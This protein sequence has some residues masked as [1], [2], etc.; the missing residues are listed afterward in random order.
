MRPTR[1]PRQFRLPV[2]HR[3]FPELPYSHLRVHVILGTDVLV[4][5][6]RAQFSS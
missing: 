3:V 1:M 5:A 2:E 4:S 6:G